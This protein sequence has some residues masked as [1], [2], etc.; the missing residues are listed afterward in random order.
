MTPRRER[1]RQ[2]FDSALLDLHAGVL[3]AVDAVR[4]RAKTNRVSVGILFDRVSE[5]TATG[6]DAFVAS[7][8]YH[9]HL[10]KMIGL[11]SVTQRQILTRRTPGKMTLLDVGVVVRGE[12]G[13]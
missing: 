12:I 2:S 1:P 9:R 7:E 11:K 3:D 13:P 5:R 4:G 6:I 8:A 10:L